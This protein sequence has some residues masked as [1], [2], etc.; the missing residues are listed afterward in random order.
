MNAIHNDVSEILYTN[1]DLVNACER[2]GKQISTDYEGKRP[3]LIALLKG[4]VPF[5]AELVKHITCDME[6]DF[7]KTKSYDGTK[8]TGKVTF[9]SDVLTDINGRDLI[10]VE[11]I[12][13]TGRTLKAVMEEYYNRGA[14]SIELVALLN[15]PEGRKIE[16]IAP[17]YIG[18]EVPNKFVVGFGLDY[19]ELYRNLPYIGVLK[20]SIYKK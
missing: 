2:I 3:V 20:E 11:D 10:F 9:Y 17:K 4:S 18:Y 13:D 14:K 8:S 12:I 5:F 19:N 16:G 1:E 7:I 6:M 15:K